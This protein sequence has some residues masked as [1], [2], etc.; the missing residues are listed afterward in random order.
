MGAAGVGITVLG[1]A[2]ATATKQQ[3]L[4]TRWLRARILLV[5][6]TTAFFAAGTGVLPM[7]RFLHDSI[8][9]VIG[10]S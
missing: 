1:S 10:R 8:S 6:T 4:G 5:G 9:R 2:Y 7:P 3:K